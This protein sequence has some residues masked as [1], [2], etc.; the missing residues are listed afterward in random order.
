MTKYKKKINMNLVFN[1]NFYKTNFTIYIEWSTTTSKKYINV[2]NASNNKFYSK[3]KRYTV[4]KKFL[5]WNSL[6]KKNI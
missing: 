2:T 4:N 6:K 5:A 1:F 3:S